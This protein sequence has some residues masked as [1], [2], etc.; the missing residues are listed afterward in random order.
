MVES[1]K[2]NNSIDRY[3]VQERKLSLFIHCSC[4]STFGGVLCGFLMNMSRDANRFINAENILV[5]AISPIVDVGI[6]CRW[7]T[8]GFCLCSI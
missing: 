6:S 4:N 7:I 1:H 3:P 8:I 5:L 2:G